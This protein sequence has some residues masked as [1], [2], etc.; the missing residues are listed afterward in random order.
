LLSERVTELV[1]DSES[2]AF[3]LALIVFGRALLHL[4]ACVLVVAVVAVDRK[5][6]MEPVKSKSSWILVIV[7]A[8][9]DNPKISSSTLVSGKMRSVSYVKMF[10]I[11][12]SA[13]VATHRASVSHH[14]SFA[15]SIAPSVKTYVA[16]PY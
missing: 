1:N 13:F 14:A 15:L 7:E 2:V 5:V 11:S 3:V 8:G 4:I 16:L 9:V 12:W 10:V 6:E